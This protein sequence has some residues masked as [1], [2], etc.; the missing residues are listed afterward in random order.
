MNNKQVSNNSKPVYELNL[1]EKIVCFDVSISSLHS[2]NIVLVGFKRR[3]VI[4]GIE[5]PTEEDYTFE[6]KKIKEIPEFDTTILKLNSQPILR[7]ILFATCNAN[8]EIKIFSVDINTNET[9]LVQKLDGH[10]NYIN[11]IDFSED[12]LASGSD[13][14]T[15]KIY[16]CKENY[17]ES[18]VLNF[19]SSVTCVK[20]NTEEPTK[21]LINVKNGNLFIF[22]LKLRQSLYSFQTQSP[23]MWLDWSIKNP[24]FV[25]SLAGDQILYFDI[26]KPDIPIY[27]K[28]INDVGK[29]IKIHPQNPLVSAVICSRSGSDLKVIHQKSNIPI[30]NSK[31]L[32]YSGLA[33]FNGYLVAGSDRKLCFFKV[34]VA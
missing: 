32:S 27:N 7:N 24:C 1:N 25:A 2:E 9:S 6:H 16:S 18:L 31:L 19:S 8:Y 3:I 4:L 22:C 13:D 21:L 15:C 12:Y 23:L 14:H 10:N 20:F 34:H 29:I 26:S 28:R 5:F 33:W 11:S 17:E 30:F